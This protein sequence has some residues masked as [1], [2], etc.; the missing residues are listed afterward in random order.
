MASKHNIE[1]SST[2]YNEVLKDAE[3]DLVVITTRHNLHAPMVKQAI[4][5]GKNVFV[6]KP[7]AITQLDLNEIIEAQQKSN[8][9]I[10]VGFNRRFSPHIQQI[11]S[12]LPESAQK[13]MIAT[14]N[15]GNIPSD[16]WV[17]DM[18]VGGGRIIGEACHYIDLLVYLS[19]SKVK[20][21]CMNSMGAN[22]AENTDNV[23]ILLKFENGDNGVVN[24]FANGNKAYSKERLEVYFDE[25]TFI[26]DNFRETRGF[27]V[28]GF[29][30]LKTKLDKGHKAQFDLLSKRIKEGGAPLIPIDEIINVSKAS[31]S[32]IESMKQG[33]WVEV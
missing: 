24:Y 22:P 11:K 3:V 21:I 15:A 16:V 2:D 18:Q 19:G 25:K 20:S 27:G 13:N 12:K 5:S 4:A 10:T 33:A 8:V 28:K 7:L 29:T 30:K 23:S 1:F 26:M 9:N 32:A 14:M 17:H 6:E 31:I